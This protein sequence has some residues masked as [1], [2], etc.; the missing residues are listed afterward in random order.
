[1]LII[2]AISKASFRHVQGTTSCDLWLSLE[3]AYAPHSTSREYTLKTQLLRIEMHGD[4]THDA[5]LNR[6]Q[7]YADALAAIGEPVK[8]KNL[9]MLVVL[10]YREEYIDL[11][12]TLTA[13][14]SP[15]A[16]SELHALL[17]DHDYML[18][19]TRARAPSIT[20]SFAVNYAVGS[21][22]MLEARQAQLLEL[23]AQL[24]ALG[25]QVSP[26]TPSGP[27]AFY[28]ARSNNNNNN[29]RS[30]N[31]NNRGNYNNSRGNNNRGRGNGLWFDWAS[32]Q[33]IIYGTCNR[34]DTGTNIHVTPDLAVMDTSEAYY[35][36]D[37]LHVGNGKG[38][39]FL[40][41]GSSKVY[42]PQKIFSLKNILHVPEISHNILSVQKFCHDNDV[43]FE[44]HNSYFVV[45]DEST[46]TTLLTG[47]SKHGLYTITLPQLKSINKVSFSAV[48]ASPTIWHRRLGHPHQSLLRSML[49]NFSL[50]VTN[51][52]LSSFCNSCPLGKSSKLPLLESGFRKSPYVIPTTDH[53]SPTSPR[54]PISSPSSVSHLSPTSQT[55][56]ESSNGQLSPVST[57]SIP[58]P[59]PPTPPPPPPIT[60][61]RP[62][63]LCQNPKQRVPYNPSANHATVLPTTITESNSFTVANNSPE[64]FQDMK[65]EYDAFMKNRT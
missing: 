50:H 54:S 21:P 49:S 16:F 63:N 42:S 40:H 59:P 60:G 41:I 12:T 17:S 37:A 53:P 58:T 26:I 62:A 14:Q 34:C 9:V 56:P 20:S 55:S 32:T 47:P 28:G 46:H 15:T 44:F 4:E 45:K 24:S 31:N 51:K 23:T 27:Q 11:K 8:D 6:A 29:N 13:R 3:K 18:G 10:G 1:M 36:D 39:P 48:R 35:G 57:T 64:W 5:Y 61:Q 65:A 38:L 33:N 30:N 25:F 22:S 7:E 19:K 43:F 52:S 2:S